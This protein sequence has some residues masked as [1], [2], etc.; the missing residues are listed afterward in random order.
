MIQITPNQVRPVMSSMFDVSMPTGIRAL[1]VLAGGNKGKIFTD[2]PDHP[3][4]AFVW[5]ADDG[6]LYRGGEYDKDDLSEAVNVLRQEGVVALGFHD[7]DSAQDLLPPNPDA[8]AE[9]LE[10]D[11]PIG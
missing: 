10:F 8:G 9:C 4:W 11:R 7:G 6:T 5:E 2:D 3:R 1:A